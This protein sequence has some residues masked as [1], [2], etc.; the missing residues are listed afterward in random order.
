MYDDLCNGVFLWGVG[1]ILILGIVCN[2]DCLE[3]NNKVF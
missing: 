3:L 1:F 2:K